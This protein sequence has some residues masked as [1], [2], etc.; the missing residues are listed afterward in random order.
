MSTWT[1]LLLL[2]V[3]NHRQQATHPAGSACI[4][5]VTNQM[6]DSPEAP[7]TQAFQA[8]EANRNDTCWQEAQLHES[9]DTNQR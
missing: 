7:P 9:Q 5:V 2:F 3:P 6:K 8:A 4:C 1:Q